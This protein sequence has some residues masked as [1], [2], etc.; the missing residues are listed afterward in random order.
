MVHTF[1]DAFQATGSISSCMVADHL[2]KVH[3]SE[4]DPS[5]YKKAVKESA[6]TAFGGEDITFNVFLLG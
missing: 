4:D 3:E 2:L 5:W 6:A 1:T